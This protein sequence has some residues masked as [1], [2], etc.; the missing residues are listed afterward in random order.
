MYKI[1]YDL[2]AIPSHRHR[3]LLNIGV[4]G[5]GKPSM[6]NFNPGGGG[7]GGVLQKETYRHACT[8]THMF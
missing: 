8:C 2:V 1:T 6:A 7:G 3:K 5:G 4:G